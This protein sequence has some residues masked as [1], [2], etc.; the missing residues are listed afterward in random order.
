ML[1]QKIL[2]KLAVIVSHKKTS[3]KNKG[4]SKKVQMPPFLHLRIAHF[5]DIFALQNLFSHDKV[6]KAF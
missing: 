2:M 3:V 1:I 6:T 4:K 5:S